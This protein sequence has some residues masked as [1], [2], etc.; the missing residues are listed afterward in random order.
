MVVKIDFINPIEHKKHSLRKEKRMKVRMLISKKGC[1][2]GIHVLDYDAGKSYDMPE[3]LA[4][5]MVENGWA[6]EDKAM[7]RAP[8]TKAK[9]ETKAATRRSRVKKK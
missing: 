2:D 8:E 7:D 1:P 5:V 3:Q 6:E 9:Q 4:N